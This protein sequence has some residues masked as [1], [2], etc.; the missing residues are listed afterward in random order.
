MTRYDLTLDTV[1]QPDL[2]LGLMV[3]ALCAGPECPY[4]HFRFHTLFQGINRRIVLLAGMQ[5]P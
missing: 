3:P 4:F 1:H 2:E 5:A